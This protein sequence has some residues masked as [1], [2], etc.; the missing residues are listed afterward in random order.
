VEDRQQTMHPHLETLLQ[1][2]DLKSQRRELAEDEG[3]RQVEE[4]EFKVDIE[5]ALQEIDRKIEEL[6]AELPP[7]VRSR[8]GRLST[9]GR[10]VVPMIGGICYGC[11]VSIPT[12]ITAEV[13][14]HSGLLTCDNC[15]R[16][17]Y[18]VG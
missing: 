5:E 11:F 18:G 12:A 3:E 14:L 15:G 1:L 16:F 9:G 2:Q 10:A 6:E 17:L 8:Y 13:V 4:Q 7:A